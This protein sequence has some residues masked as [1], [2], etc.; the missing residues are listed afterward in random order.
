[1]ERT[2][3]SWTTLFHTYYVLGLTF[4][5]PQ[6]YVYCQRTHAHFGQQLPFST[7]MCMV[8]E[9]TRTLDV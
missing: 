5:Y 7:A 4:N 1:M 2:S 9:V 3:V 8:L 6:V